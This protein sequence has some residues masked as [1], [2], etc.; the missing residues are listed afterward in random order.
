MVHFSLKYAEFSHHNDNICCF[1][2]LR[3]TG[4]ISSLLEDSYETCHYSRLDTVTLPKFCELYRPC[5]WTFKWV[6]HSSS[7][8]F[9]FSLFEFFMVLYNH[10]MFFW[11][12]FMFKNLCKKTPKTN[13]TKQQINT[14]LFLKTILT[15]VWLFIQSIIPL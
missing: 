9:F 12:S 15:F 14:L 1:T 4:K 11:F 13:Q 8:I 6:L 10:F 2:C 5:S 3:Q 7:K